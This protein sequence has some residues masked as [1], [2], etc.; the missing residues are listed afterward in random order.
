M[1]GDEAGHEEVGVVVA[2]LAAQRQFLAG[3]GAGGLQQV[4]LIPDQDVEMQ[5]GSW[6]KNMYMKSNRKY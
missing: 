1:V 6:K 4:G 5:V 3:G 2:G